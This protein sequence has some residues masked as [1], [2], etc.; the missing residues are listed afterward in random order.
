MLNRLISIYNNNSFFLFGPRGSGKTRLLKST[1]GENSW[2]IDLLNLE[3]EAKY[4]QSPELL[5]KESG[6]ISSDKIIIIDEIQ[7]VPA[8]LDVAHRLI[9]EGRKIILTG[10]SARKL[11]M[12]AANLLAGRAFLKHLYPFTLTELEQIERFSSIQMESGGTDDWGSLKEILSYG[13]LPKIFEL[14]QIEKVDFLN[15]YALTYL[16]EEIFAEQIIRR[17]DPFSKFLEI[18][19]E[20]HGQEINFSSIAKLIKV[21]TITVQNY[22]QILEDTLVGFMLEAYG[23]SSRIRLKSSPKFYFFD[24]GV[25]RALDRSIY[26][27]IVHSS[28]EFGFLFEQLIISELKRL[29]DYKNNGFRFYY[30]RDYKKREVDLVIIKPNKEKILVEIKSGIL[31]Q[32]DSIKLVSEIKNEIAAVRAIILSR[33]QVGYVDRG[34]EVMNWYGGLKSCLE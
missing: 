13:T 14:S 21:E 24:N 34:V 11:K 27:P 4:R 32:E 10:S 19:S 2:Y 16:K 22:F 28:F 23:G 31:V 5:Y 3:T 33:V 1:F 26:A 9:E 6:V 17:I 20:S 8:L 7:K 15:S 12:G 30:Y 25:K 18:A 29:S